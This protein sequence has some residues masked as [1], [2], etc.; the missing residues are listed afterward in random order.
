LAFEVVDHA[1]VTAH[2]CRSC[3]DS[4]HA[5]GLPAS[6]VPTGAQ[7][8]VCHGTLAW[9]P[10][11]VDHTTLTSRCVSCHNNTAALGVPATHMNKA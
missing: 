11:K 4:V 7:C 6:H 3:H 8:D 9:K 5:M 1:A 10:A 2:T